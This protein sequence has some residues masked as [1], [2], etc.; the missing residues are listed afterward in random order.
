VVARAA[1]EGDTE[2]QE[3]LQS[4]AT[5]LSLLVND[6]VSRLNLRE[7]KFLLVKTGGMVQGSRYFDEQVNE[8]LKKAAPHAEFGVLAVAAAEAAARIAL[9]MVRSEGDKGKERGRA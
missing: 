1:D 4:A 2:A 8:R 5:E 7:Q 9:R 3:L 6:L